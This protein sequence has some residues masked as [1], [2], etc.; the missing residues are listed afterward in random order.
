MKNY[1]V[2]ITL[3]VSLAIT[4]KVKAQTSTNLTADSVV[5]TTNPA[6]VDNLI[7]ITQVDASS[8]PS[9]LGSKKS[10][11]TRLSS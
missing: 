3:G 6:D 9:F 2:L 5:L 8:K 4:V 11:L 1:L 7:P 10:L